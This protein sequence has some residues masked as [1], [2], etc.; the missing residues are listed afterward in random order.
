LRTSKDQEVALKRR[1]IGGLAGPLILDPPSSQDA[2]TETLQE[3]PLH[4]ECVWS[5]G[6]QRTSV[7][8]LRVQPSVR[9]MDMGEKK[10]PSRKKICGR[11][12][13]KKG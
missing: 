7:G 1:A 6:D 2:A 9:F 4:D 3:R 13:E 5:L 12:S 10:L 8:Q 11:Q